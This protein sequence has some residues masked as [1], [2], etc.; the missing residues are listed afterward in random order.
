M[1]NYF[2]I[3]QIP[4]WYFIVG[5]IVRQLRNETKMLSQPLKL[6]QDAS[7]NPFVELACARW[8]IFLSIIC[9]YLMVFSKP[10]DIWFW[11]D[12]CRDSAF[13]FSTVVVVLAC[14]WINFL[15]KLNNIQLKKVQYG[16]CYF[17]R[18][19]LFC[20]SPVSLGWCNPWFNPRVNSAEW[21]GPPIN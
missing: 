4:V 9:W 3:K 21:I 5:V 15:V 13:R 19:H 17:K 12:A 11:F 2:I 14:C 1:V 18:T 10:F 7:K 20:V 6:I 8:Q 16:K